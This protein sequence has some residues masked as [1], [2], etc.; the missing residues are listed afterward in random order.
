LKKRRRVW[1]GNKNEQV[2]KMLFNISETW[3]LIRL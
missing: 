2:L 3:P 1:N